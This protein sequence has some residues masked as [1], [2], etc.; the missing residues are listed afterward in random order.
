M[1]K[2]LK[3][4]GAKILFYPA[5]VMVVG[6]YDKEGRPNVMTA[7][8]GGVCCSAPPSIA[9][10]LRK[11]T[12]SYGN[13]VERKA[14]T[15]SIPSEAHMKEADYFGMV[16]GKNEDKFKATGLTPV[17]SQVVDAPYV[18]E[19]PFIVECRLIHTV[20]I[21]LH[22]QFI[23]EVADIKV[24]PSVLSEN[25]TTPDIEKLRPLIFTPESRLYYGVGNLLG[26]AFSVGKR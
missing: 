21:G 10:S 6:T 3:S 9:V 25:G 14:F 22:T 19:F 16:S 2:K 20:E 12:Y 1:E 26:K 18:G 7:A 17:R 8:W 5:P 15:I 11:A 4:L 24:D 23:G 13:L